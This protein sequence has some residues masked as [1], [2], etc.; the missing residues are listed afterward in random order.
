MPLIIKKDGRREPYAREKIYHGIKKACQ[1]TAVPTQKIEELVART[2]KRIQTYG[3][4]EV[5]SKTIGKMVM[6]ELHKLNKVAYVRFASVYREFEDV[7]EFVA[8]LQEPTLQ[9]NDPS[10]MMFPFASD[11]ES[12]QNTTP[13][14][15]DSR[16]TK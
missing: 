15:T 13:E 11:S 6:A 5:P 3:L 16:V 10:L 14:G 7:E 8:E 9:N 2:E 1:K 12:S 4:K